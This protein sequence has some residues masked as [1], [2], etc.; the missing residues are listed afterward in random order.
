MTPPEF[1]SFLDRC[2]A[3]HDGVCEAVDALTPYPEPRYAVALQSGRLSIEHGI[4]AHALISANLAAPGITLL[5][6]QFETLVRAVWLMYAASDAWVDKLGGPLTI[7]TVESG[8][9]TPMLAKMLQGLRASEGAPPAL[10]DQ[11]ESCRDAHWK[12]LNSYAHGGLHP[13]ARSA[14]GYPLKLCYD[15]LRNSSGLTALAAQLCA[16][17]SGKPLAMVPIRA[18]HEN[19]RDVLPIIEPPAQTTTRTRQ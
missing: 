2:A 13:L 12:A 9:D 15:V 4:A 11:L 10:L 18:L 16:I 17:V 1:Q 5:R 6:T 14:T 8:N 19:Y 3:F 7:E